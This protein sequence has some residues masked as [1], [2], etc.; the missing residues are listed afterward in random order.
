MIAADE[1]LG[2]V[3]LTEMVVRPGDGVR[4]FAI[5]PITKHILFSE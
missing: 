2:A 4:F 5:N 3:G 1:V